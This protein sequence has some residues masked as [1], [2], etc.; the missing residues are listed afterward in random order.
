MK[1]VDKEKWECETHSVQREWDIKTPNG[2]TM[3]G[4]WVLRNQYGIV[5]DFDGYINDL[6][7]R[8]NLDLY[9]DARK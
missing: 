5:I 7:D 3:N 9:S 6:A 2:N 1:K 4:R 8:W